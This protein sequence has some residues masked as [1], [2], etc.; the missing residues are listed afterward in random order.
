MATVSGV[1]V[2]ANLHTHSHASAGTYAPFDH[3]NS[4]EAPDLVTE[5]AGYHLDFLAITDHAEAVTRQEWDANAT[6]AAH[7][8][9]GLLAMRGFEWTHVTATFQG[10][11]V[12]VFGTVEQVKASQEE[13]VEACGNTLPTTPQLYNWLTTAQSL[14]DAPVVAQFNHLAMPGP[15]FSDFA[16]PPSSTVRDIVALAELAVTRPRTPPQ[17]VEPLA[18][19]WKPF[20]FNIRDGE[21]LWR[22]AL[23]HGWRVAP[24]LNADNDG[25][26]EPSARRFHT[27]IFLEPGAAVTRQSVLKAL[28][29]RRTFASQDADAEIQLWYDERFMGSEG[30]EV[31][32]GSS[33]RLRY[34]HPEADVIVTHLDVGD[35]AIVVQGTE[36]PLPP[37][38]REEDYW[39][40]DI[41][42][43]KAPGDY[44]LYARLRQLPEFGQLSGGDYIF[45]APIW[46]TVPGGAT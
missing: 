19:T 41:A 4:P 27:G 35:S 24:T 8:P 45:S 44:Y 14:Y 46:F 7:A 3:N 40:W 33:F 13:G 39:V 5:A 23:E 17:R 37:P 6:A 36:Q 15:H 9:A 32:P 12:N 1:L 43:P 29:A 34:R 25:C 18:L 10:E 30:V 2:R 42:V 38:R 26:F 28:A 11:H 20:P 22:R 21:V 31:Q 16:P